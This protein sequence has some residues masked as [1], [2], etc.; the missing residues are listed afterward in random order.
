V[1]AHQDVFDYRDIDRDGAE[2]EES[3]PAERAQKRDK[4]DVRRL[5]G[6]IER[7]RERALVR[8]DLRLPR[9]DFGSPAGA[10]PILGHTGEYAPIKKTKQRS[11]KRLT[12]EALCEYKSPDLLFC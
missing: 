12:G 7:L 1:R 4:P 3:E 6:K 5:R 10:I 11:E 8:P 9:L 2:C